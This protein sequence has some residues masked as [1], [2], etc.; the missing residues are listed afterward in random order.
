[1]RLVNKN[2]G[3]IWRY[4]RVPVNHILTYGDIG[5]E[6]SDDGIWKICFGSIQLG[7]F[8]ERIMV[9]MDKRGGIFVVKRNLYIRLFNSTPGLKSYHM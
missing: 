9:I 5:S 6:E 7:R 4:V 8:D 3:I 2:A 1:M